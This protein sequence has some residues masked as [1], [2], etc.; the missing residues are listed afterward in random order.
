MQNVSNNMHSCKDV[1]FTVKIA[2]FHTPWSPGPVKHWKIF[3]LGIFF[4]SIWPLKLDVLRENTPYSSSEPNESD[5]VNRQIGDQK[6][7]VL[8][9]CI[10]GIHHL[11]SHMCNDDSELSLWAHDVWGRISRKPLEIEAWFKRNTNRKWPMA[12]RMV[13]WPMMSRDPQKVENSK[14][15]K[16][17]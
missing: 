5:I 6:W 13:T 15:R 14:Y 3:G 12:S 1:P 16:W 4:C 9:F 11:I 2:T 7:N 17:L 8:K 10:G